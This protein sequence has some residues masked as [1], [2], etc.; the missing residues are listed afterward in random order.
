MNER[1]ADADEGNERDADDRCSVGRSCK[2]MIAH[3]SSL[4][5]PCASSPRVPVHI[6]VPWPAHCGFSCLALPGFYCLL[7]LF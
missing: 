2:L 5:A 4:Y 3:V 6:H 1:D 7:C